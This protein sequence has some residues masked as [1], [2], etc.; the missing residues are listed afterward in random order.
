MKKI[1]F[2]ILWV[3]LIGANAEALTR[4]VAS[5][6]SGQPTPCHTSINAALSAAS[7]GDTIDIRAG[8]YAEFLHFGLGT[9]FPRSTSWSTATIIQAHVG[10][11]VTL[12]PPNTN[13]HYSAIDMYG[14]AA[15]VPFYLWFR[16]TTG[17]NFIIDMADTGSA[18]GSGAHIEGA[19]VRLDS[20]EIKNA[21]GSNYPTANS[22]S[23]GIVI[24]GDFSEIINSD[25][26]DNGAPDV[27]GTP[28][29]GYAI[30]AAAH[31]SVI[32]NNLMHDNAGF[33]I[34]IFSEGEATPTRCPSNVS[35]YGN[36]VY[37]NGRNTSG[38]T[39]TGYRTG[40]VV[41]GTGHKVFN[42]LVYNNGDEGI[43]DFRD[44][45]GSFIYENI[46]YG[47]VNAGLN[48]VAGGGVWRNNI[49]S[50]NGS[51]FRAG[52]SGTFSNNLCNTTASSTA[53]TTG[54]ANPTAENATATF[55]TVNSTT[56]GAGTGT[57]N[58]TVKSTSAA[59]NSGADLGA[60]SA[61]AIDVTATVTTSNGSLIVTGG[62]TRPQA[63]A[64]D[65][66]AYEGSAAAGPT[67]AITSPG[68]DC[69]LA[70]CAVGLAP[71]T[72]SGTSSLTTT[73]TVIWSCDRC[74]PATGTATERATWSTS[75]LTLKPGINIIIVTATDGAGNTA[76]AQ[77]SI[78]YRP[79]FPGNTLAGAWAFD[80]PSGNTATDSSGNSNTGTLVNSP[81]RVAG[82]Y[83]SAIQLNGTNQSIFIANNP[84]NSLDLTQS[85]SITAMVQPTLVSGAFRAIVYKNSQPSQAS[86]YSLYATVQGF[87]GDG[88]LMGMTN[89]N[90]SSGPRYNA[91]NST[92][93]AVGTWT[94]VAI[95][96]DGAN[97]RLYKSS[98][99][100]ITLL[101]TAPAIGYIEPSTGTLQIGASEFNEYFQ[102]LIDNVRLY[103]WA[104]PLSDGGN[105]TL[106][107]ACASAAGVQTNI[108]TPSLY[109]DA[110]CPIIP[111]TAPTNFS[112]GAA[113]TFAIGASSTFAIGQ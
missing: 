15:N 96:Y 70:A 30:Y 76:I 42:N 56:W 55:N 43:G 46:V 83:G 12:K 53:C 20:M 21:Q 48:G 110:N 84:N 100:T 47:N 5:N 7:A 61:Y 8:T 92:P 23:S 1:F 103:N 71:I 49:V 89:T 19:Y 31:S 109:G 79:N 68:T 2:L 32:A 45:S 69:S 112:I 14:G 85:F 72:V 25:I 62:V 57:T 17:R 24:H 106:G 22:G 66:G 94:F 54:T 44:I 58:L 28:E 98:G 26:H 104:I 37:N 41:C 101:S 38:L 63:G 64:W 99:T 75:S 50:N 108:A 39:S 6:C 74:T 51:Y 82:R 52:S 27:G 78:T 97:L 59:R 77:R 40:V 9:N 65:I 107:A 16:G 11:T 86:P 67:V 29:G 34:Q 13:P 33:G 105:T 93:L 88:G 3:L 87:C 113:S 35:F 90:G 80:E 4:T 60:G 102:G 73:G 18:G 91:C 10:E 36:R 81:T 111:V 95:T